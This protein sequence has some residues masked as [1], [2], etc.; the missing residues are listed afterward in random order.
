MPL[1]SVLSALVLKKFRTHKEVNT[2]LCIQKNMEREK[3]TGEE[4]PLANALLFEDICVNVFEKLSQEQHVSLKE[5]QNIILSEK[6]RAYFKGES[7]Y[8]Y[9][10]LLVPTLDRERTYNVKEHKLCDLYS[11]VLMCT[12]LTSWKTTTGDLSMSVFSLLTERKQG[13][14]GTSM[15]L[16]Q[17]NYLLDQFATKD[18]TVQQNVIR[19][20][21]FS[22]GPLQHKWLVR[23]IL[24]SMRVGISDITFLRL[25]HPS[26]ENDFSLHL[27]L[28]KVLGSRKT[29]SR[30]C[31]FT[32]FAPMLSKR[33]VGGSDLLFGAQK[34]IYVE[35]KVDGERLLVHLQHGGILHTR[36]CFFTRN[37]L[38]VTDLYGPV[39]SDPLIRT[40]A[41]GLAH[42]VVLDGEVVAWNVA[43]DRA[44]PFGQNKVVAQR[45]LNQGSESPFCLMLFLFDVVMFDGNDV[46]GLPLWRR[47]DLLQ[48]TVELGNFHVRM[49]PYDIIPSA[50]MT[51]SALNT[52]LEKYVSSSWEGVLLKGSSSIYSLGEQGRKLRSSWV[53]VKPDYLYPIAADMD[54]VVVGMYQEKGQR[55]GFEGQGGCPSFLMAMQAADNTF[56]P[57]VKA[58]GSGLGVESLRRV[59]ERLSPYWTKTRPSIVQEE[60]PEPDFWIGDPFLSVVLEV[61]GA[62]FLEEEK[63]NIKV[64]FPRIVR[65]RPDKDVQDIMQLEELLILRRRGGTFSRKPEEEREEGGKISPFLPEK[66]T[67]EE[68]GIFSSLK[69][70]VFRGDYSPYETTFEEIVSLLEEHGASLLLSI[71]PNTDIL[72]APDLH[73]DDGAQRFTLKGIKNALDVLLPTWILDCVREGRLVE[74]TFNHYLLLGN[75]ETKESFKPFLDKFGDHWTAPLTERRLRETVFPNIPPSS[76][77]KEKDYAMACLLQ[78]PSL[79]LLFDG[80]SLSGIAFSEDE[81]VFS[82]VL[83]RACLA[84]ARNHG[85]VV[86]SSLPPPGYVVRTINDVWQALIEKGGGVI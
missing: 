37:G 34:S 51:Y 39:L 61:H 84:I 58:S 41:P 1:V 46:R 17:I 66:R 77:E 80:N 83:Q 8:P 85:A 67:R 16:G 74:K 53:K 76:S 49:L 63:G 28:K 73:A 15:T 6:K 22:L 25:L 3:R 40:L 50:E 7:M 48:K 45:Q 35:P 21:I 68:E 65:A 44:L 4:T 19:T 26:A 10:R 42:R 11:A 23:I 55:N 60:F 13:G 31:L 38:D 24:K 33:Y 86:F 27:D 71:T 12:S 36:T 54:L 32:P 79:P 2:S 18:T 29:S 57:F 69:A 30:L 5:K 78:E 82:P 43:E 56:I 52:T 59:Q 75:K 81:S 47:K 62:S 70:Y 20:C 14:G 72:V 64:R 9:V